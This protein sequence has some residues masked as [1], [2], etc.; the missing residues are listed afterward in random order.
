MEKITCIVHTFNSEKY[1]D[2]CLAHLSWADEILLIDMYSTDRT[3]DI[4]KLH[5]CKILMHEN[6]G[7]VE[8]ARQFGVNKSSNDWIMSV[9]SDEI[10][11]L[12]LAKQLKKVANENSS[13]VVKISF[14]NYF[15]GKEII[16][17]GWS[18]KDQVIPRFFNRN[19][20]TY[21][22]KIHSSSKILEGARVAKIIDKDKSILHFN[23]DS[24]EQFISK[25]NR[26]TNVESR[27]DRYVGS[28]K[29]RMLYQ[30]LR[31]FFGRLIVKKGYKDGWL[32]IYLSFAMAFYRMTAI[33][34]AN[35]DSNNVENINN[36]IAADTK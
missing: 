1:L 33:A 31:E 34:K 8:P 10:V 25:L 9:D 13:D 2:Q 30:F 11:P 19:Y 28:I 35:L 32:G 5:G 12:A 21:G 29:R 20:L 17:S 27:D 26:Y 16:G 24:V 4:A 36:E 22:S 7:Y 6:V 18:Y 23:Y 15:F 14:R 3:L